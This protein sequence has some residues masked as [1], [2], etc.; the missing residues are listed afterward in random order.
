MWLTEIFPG[1]TYGH[2]ILS[3]SFA[4]I[5]PTLFQK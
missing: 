1:F 2:A 5:G 4:A 3:I